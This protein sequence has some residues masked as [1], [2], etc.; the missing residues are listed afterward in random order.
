MLC[1]DRTRREETHQSAGGKK[2][3]SPGLGRVVTSPTGVAQAGGGDLGPE[4]E[5]FL[6]H[7]GSFRWTSEGRSVT[8]PAV[9]PL[10]SAHARTPGRRP[11]CA[12][13]VPFPWS[14]RSLVFPSVPSAPS[15]LPRPG[16]LCPP[17]PPSSYGSRHQLGS[18][19]SIFAAC[20]HLLP[21]IPF[22]ATQNLPQTCALEQQNFR[23]GIHSNPCTQ[24]SSD[25]GIYS[26]TC[27]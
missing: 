4:R 5:T 9:P 8:S 14:E 3:G 16:S 24:R 12:P 11:L 26:R 18:T 21:M 13:P 25:Q 17:L 22:Q 27:T 6:Q 15:P 20:Q 1:A 10:P 23:P 2:N 7:L 19:Q